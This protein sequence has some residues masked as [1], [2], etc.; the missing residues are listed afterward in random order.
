MDKAKGQVFF[1]F[2]FKCGACACAQVRA[3]VRVGCSYNCASP[4]FAATFQHKR[5]WPPHR[6][7]LQHTWINAV[8]LPLKGAGLCVHLPVCVCVFCVCC[9]C[10][11]V[12]CVRNRNYFIFFNACASHLS[13]PTFASSRW[14]TAS[15]WKWADWCREM[16]GTHFG[17]EKF[18]VC[19]IFSPPSGRILT[20]P[21]LLSKNDPSFIPIPPK[22]LGQQFENTIKTRVGINLW[23][24][25]WN[26][27]ERSNN[28]WTTANEWTTVLRID[29]TL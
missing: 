2:F 25:K 8:H 5:S 16:S 26:Q 19:C 3:Y 18:T 20:F 22:C 6:P 11:C 29:A 7:L 27:F 12:V 9:V 21:K 15:V 14:V 23:K 28:S 24:K 17:R 1:F 4:P 10:V 13:Q